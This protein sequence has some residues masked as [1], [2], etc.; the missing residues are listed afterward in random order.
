MT[1]GSDLWRTIARN[2]SLERPDVNP[3]NETVYSGRFEYEMLSRGIVAEVGTWRVDLYYD[4]G[5]AL[6]SGKI[7]CPRGPN[8]PWWQQSIKSNYILFL[9]V[10][11]ICL[12]STIKLQH[13]I[14]DRQVIAMISIGAFGWIAKTLAGI[15]IVNRSDVVAAFGSFCIGVT[16][17][18]Y[19]RVTGRKPS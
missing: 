9:F 8:L 3:V 2:T 13:P 11:I 14:K 15:Y 4:T 17:N 12:L 16:G 6:S 10:P 1:I 7:S 5:S 18:I 19:S